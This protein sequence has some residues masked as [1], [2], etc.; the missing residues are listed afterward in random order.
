MRLKFDDMRELKERVVE[1]VDEGRV[2]IIWSH[3]R[4]RHDVRRHEI[5]M[6]LRHGS[7]LKPDKVVEGRYVVWSRLTEERR[8]ARVVFEIQRVNGEKLVVV[9]AFEEG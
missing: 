4:A 1:L 3:I 5:L 8:L 6:A 2:E 7:P 9:T